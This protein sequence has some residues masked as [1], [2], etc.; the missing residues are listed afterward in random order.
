[1]IETN[2]AQFQRFAE[3]KACAAERAVIHRLETKVEQPIARSLSTLGSAWTSRLY[4]G[5]FHLFDPPAGL[6]SVTLVF[7][8][9]R[10]GNTVTRNPQDLGG[11][12]ADQHLIYE[13]L[14]RVA[15]DAVLAGAATVGSEAFF[16]VWHPELVSLRR[17]LSRSRH[18]AQIVVSADGR[19]DV[20][21]CLL[22]NVPDVPVFVLAGEACRGRCRVTLSR[23]PWITVVPLERDGLAG[24]LARLRQEHRIQRI[25][26]IG[27]R[28]T[29]SS[30]I[31][32]GLVQDLLL[33]TTARSGGDPNT[34]FYVGSRPPPRDLIVR[35]TGT[36]PEYPIVVEHFALRR[37]PDV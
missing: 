8:Q 26:A 13:G 4:D 1:M 27:G 21:R 33:T 37:D 29:A 24:A 18:P 7:V 23:R 16:S 31:D 35:K 25:S 34:P 15:A 12:P 10:E 3:R 20:D 9:S 28:T 19:V 11:G 36:D 14:S 30:L 22:F 5:G 17:D 6:P 2:T 32:A